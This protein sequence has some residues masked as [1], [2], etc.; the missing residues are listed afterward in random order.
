MNNG[1]PHFFRLYRQSNNPK[2]QMLEKRYYQNLDLNILQAI[3]KLLLFSSILNKP[4]FDCENLLMI[5]IRLLLL[6]CCRISY[7]AFCDPLVK[8][9][10]TN[11]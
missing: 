9:Y 11:S 4:D 6:R 3:T 1:R 5:C 8:Q 10:D 7:F 2:I